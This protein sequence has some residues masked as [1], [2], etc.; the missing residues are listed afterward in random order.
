MKAII[1]YVSGVTK[2]MIE[3]KDLTFVDFC[4]ELF[5]ARIYISPVKEGKGVSIAI[6]TDNILFVEENILK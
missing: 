2:T 6:N 1:T 4:E 3:N 5:K